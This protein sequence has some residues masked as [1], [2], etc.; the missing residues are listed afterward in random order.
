[1]SVLNCVNLKQFSY[2]FILKNQFERRRRPSVVYN[3]YENSLTI[4]GGDDDNVEKW[5]DITY[6]LSRVKR[7]NY[8]YNITVINRVYIEKYPAYFVH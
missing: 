7:G 2:L 3:N 6:S 1:M 8:V 5:T 4:I